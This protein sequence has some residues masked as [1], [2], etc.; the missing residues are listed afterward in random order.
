MTLKDDADAV[1]VWW[2]RF[3][4]QR[5][6][7]PNAGPG[8]RGDRAALRRAHDLVGIVS[9]PATIDLFMRLDIRRPGQ[10]GGRADWIAVIAAVLADVGEEPARMSGG[11]S[12]ARLLG[13]APVPDGPSA[14]SE[15]R[16]RRLMQV[17]DPTEALPAFRRLVR[18]AGGKAP[19][20]DLATSL[21]TWNTDETRK[22]WVF[23]YY[24]VGYRTQHPEQNDSKADGATEETVA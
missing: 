15:H 11:N 5:A 12:L 4:G 7:H 17:G 22:R 1:W 6:G 20:R 24:G 18:M 3:V 2:N 9:I 14:L 19:V 8:L 21:L 16:F 10:P 13:P 23:D